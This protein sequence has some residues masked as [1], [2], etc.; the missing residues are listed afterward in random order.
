[1]RINLYFSFHDV[2]NLQ[3]SHLKK[4]LISQEKRINI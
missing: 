2:L 3:E 1:M 4:A